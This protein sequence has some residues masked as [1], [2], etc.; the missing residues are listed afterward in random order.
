[1]TALETWNSTETSLLSCEVPVSRAGHYKSQSGAQVFQ[2]LLPGIY[3]KWS[4]E[5]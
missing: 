3:N 1:M 2:L 4:Q 5:S